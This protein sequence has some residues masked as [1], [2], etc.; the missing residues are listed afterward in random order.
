MGFQVARQGIRRRIIRDAHRQGDSGTVSFATLNEHIQDAYNEWYWLVAND[1]RASLGRAFRSLDTT[2][3]SPVVDLP[4]EFQGLTG[5]RSLDASGQVNTLPPKLVRL[6]TALHA[7]WLG[8]GAQV[9]DFPDK[10]YRYLLEGPGQE[11]A[12]A[13]ESLVN[14]GL[15]LRRFPSFR[16]GETVT[17]TYRTQAPYLGDPSEVDTG[18]DLTP[19]ELLAPPNLRALAA[20]VR[21]RASARGDANEIQRALTELAQ[22]VAQTVAAMARE[23][24]SGT[25]TTDDYI[26]LTR[27]TAGYT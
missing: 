12:P 10:R 25:L 17:I 16:A 6:E 24:R 15:R 3:D 20:L 18:A 7:G 19:I 23:D 27:A 2:P 11:Y 13:S 22:A 8:D 5:W 9:P 14:F 1:D 26:D 21:V 4:S